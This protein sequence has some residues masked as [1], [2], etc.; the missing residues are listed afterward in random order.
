M[1]ETPRIYRLG[2]EALTCFK[3]PSELKC[4]SVEW[5]EYRP[6]PI[7]VDFTFKPWA[8]ADIRLTIVSLFDQSVHLPPIVY[9]E[10]LISNPN[11]TN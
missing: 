3:V 1:V 11:G 6:S 9:L 7:Y 10:I 8:D 2:N 5:K 4:W